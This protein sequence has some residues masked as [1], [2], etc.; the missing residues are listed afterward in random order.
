MYKLDHNK[1][2]FPRNIKE[3]NKN[4]ENKNNNSKIDSVKNLENYF[5]KLK[6]KLI[7]DYSSRQ[8]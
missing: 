1:K 2:F 4:F 6:N 8:L 5:K 7:Y 3:L